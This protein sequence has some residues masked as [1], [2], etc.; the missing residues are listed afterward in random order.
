MQRIAMFEKVPFEQ[1]RDDLFNAYGGIQAFMHKYNCS[2][3][4][5]AYGLVKSIYENIKLLALRAYW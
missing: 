5:E 1:Y 4:M 2:T 3:E